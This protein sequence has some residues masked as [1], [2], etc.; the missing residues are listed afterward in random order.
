MSRHEYSA[1]VQN[2]ISQLGWHGRLN[3]AMTPG[4]VLAM[5]RD[6][7]ASWTP[8]ELAQIPADLRPGKFVD[9]EDVAAHALMLVQ[10]QIGAA[11]GDEA[12]V[13][14]L[15]TFF[16]AASLRLSQILARSSEV[17]GEDDSASSYER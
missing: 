1:E 11:G 13:H 10:A 14:K 2:A 15:A 6:Y 17:A 8:H 5:V 3:E 9:P 7:V 16:S 12:A 4:D